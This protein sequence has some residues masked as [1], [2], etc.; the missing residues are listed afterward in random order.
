MKGEKLLRQ[1][2]TG[3][4]VRTHVGKAITLYSD[5]RWCLDEFS[6]QCWNVE[7]VHAAFSL[8]T[9]D[10]EVIRYIAATI[11]V[12]GAMVRDRMV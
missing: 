4:A 7:R 9:F 12:D 2:H 3:K 5:T 8:D 1:W 6:I 10:H 11:G